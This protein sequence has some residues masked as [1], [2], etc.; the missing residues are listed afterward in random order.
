MTPQ[1]LLNQ[2]EDCYMDSA[3]T[4]F[5]RALLEREHQDALSRISTLRADMASLE[6]A[7]DEVDAALSEQERQTILTNIDRECHNLRE[8]KLA[9]DAIEEGR[10][11]YCDDT[12]EKIG[13][14]RL[15]SNP[16]SLLC[17]E[18]KQHREDQARHLRAA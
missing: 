10:Y 17:V 3:Q 15:L 13:L 12:G 14:R 11:G 16:R 1:E 6:K 18:A 4:T 8:I 9:V 5:F 2:A 7:P